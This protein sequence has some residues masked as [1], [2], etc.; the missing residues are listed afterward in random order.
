VGDPTGQVH[1]FEPGIEPSGL[2]WT[3]PISPSAIVVNPQSGTARLRIVDLA[4]PDYHDFFNS[5]GLDPSPKPPLPSHVSFDVR[6]EGGDDPVSLADDVFGFAGTFVGGP[7]TIS[8][9]ARN[10]GAHVLY[11]SDPGGQTNVGTAA[12]GRE[13][14][15]VFLPT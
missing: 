11:W 6:W 3:I 12:V 13:R 1:D 15:G 10:D 7:A 2:F 9:A 4:L 14:N 5:V 8:F